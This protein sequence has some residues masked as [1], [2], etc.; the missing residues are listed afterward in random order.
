MR[1]RLTLALSL[2]LVS[3]T[4]RS[5]D[6]PSVVLRIPGTSDGNVTVESLRKAGTREV[7]VTSERGESVSY[8]GVPLLD[9]LES[10]GLEM[11][12]MGAGRK[13][14]PAVV[15]A[16]ARDGYTV[17][18]SAGELDMH[19]SDPRVFL[20]GATSAGALPA[21]QGPVRLVVTGQSA[22][23][24]FALARIEVRFLAENP[25]SRKK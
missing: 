25:A 13:L 10:G 24:A 11:K 6:V 5:A 20:A 16:S 14:A 8:K 4:A 22:R 12:G 9:V 2:F 7:P 23:S 19:R 17:V 15:I 21:E 1:A 18:F 3:L